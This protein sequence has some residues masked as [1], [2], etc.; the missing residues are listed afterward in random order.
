MRGFSFGLANKTLVLIDGRAVYDPLFA[1]TFW[2][3]QDVVLEDVERIEVIRGPGPTL[4]GANAVNGVINVIT[5]SAADTQGAY[6]KVGGGNEERAK[7]VTPIANSSG[8]RDP[9]QE[10]FAALR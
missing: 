9:G 2:D 8:P 1:G 3:V 7:F 4:W 10:R 5:K 6:L